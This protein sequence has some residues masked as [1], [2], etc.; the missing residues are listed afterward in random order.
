MS[1]GCL[2]AIAGFCLM[3]AALVHYA[4]GAKRRVNAW[5]EQHKDDPR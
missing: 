2:I 4:G 3:L 1:D 5:Y